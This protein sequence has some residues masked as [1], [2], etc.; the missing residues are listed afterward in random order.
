MNAYQNIGRNAVPCQPY[1]TYPSSDITSSFGVEG[2]RPAIK[3]MTSERV[4]PTIPSLERAAHD[5][6]RAS[7][8][9]MTDIMLAN[10]ARF[11]IDHTHPEYSTP[12]CLSPRLLVAADKAG[13]RIL[14]ACQHWLNVTGGLPTGQSIRLYKNNSDYKGNS[15]GCHENYLLSTELFNDLLRRKPHLIFRYLFPFFIS[16]TILCGSGKVGSEN[17]TAH[18]SFQLSQRADFFETLIGL[19]TTHER[20]LFNTR[21]EAHADP[22]RFRRLHVII[23]DANMAE[24]STYLKIGLTQLVLQ[25]LEDSFI[26]ED[27]TLADPLD[28]MLTVSRDL[29]FQ[30]PLTMEDGRSMTA[31]DIQYIY[32]DL[33]HNYLSA[34]DGSQEQW[35]ILK[36]WEEALD[37]L[38]DQ[39]ELLST[40]FD[41]AIKKRLLDRY[42]TTQ[43]ASWEEVTAW[44]PVIEEPDTLGTAKERAKRADLTWGDYERQRKLYFALRRLDLEYHDVRY[45]P[46]L[47]ETGL[48]YRLQQREAIER[49]VTDEEIQERIALPSPDT[50]SWLRGQS[51]ARFPDVL[52][53][54][55]WSG[56]E[57]RLADREV[58]LDLPDPLVNNEA[59][60]ASILDQKDNLSSIIRLQKVSGGDE[61]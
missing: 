25:M 60:T 59:E 20:P 38:P 14:A 27:L 46:D 12:E 50:R 7:K 42:L 35:N 19:D 57:F 48:F 1:I 34:R 47:G 10:G 56:M 2:S 37:M 41:W 23:G 52:V 44:Q 9:D 32:L 30:Q 29:T 21:D 58:Y 26:K 28:C 4:R 40:R 5:S 17:G 54:A 8:T 22:T 55:D 18:A 43:G 15:Y 45:N 53:S 33:A 31:L 39:W 3:T 61:P 36:K 49:L 16:R 11:Y 24:Y 6:R 51:I 13:E